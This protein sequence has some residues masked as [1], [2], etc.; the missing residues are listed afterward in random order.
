[1]EEWQDLGTITAD[2]TGRLCYEDRAVTAG[3]R[4]AYRLA[5]PDGGAVAYT[6]VTWVT[7]PALRFALRGLTPNPS[8]GDPVVAFTLT[9]GEPAALEL[10][11]VHGRLVLSREAGALGAGTHSLRL[12]SRGRLAA[13]VYTVRLRQ[14]AQVA[15]TRAVVLQ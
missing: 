9:S 7:V 4:Y 3:T 5:Y 14:G 12:D 2:G 11:D 13:G 6:P 8:A 10:F 15:S 1:M